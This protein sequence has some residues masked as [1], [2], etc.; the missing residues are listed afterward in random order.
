VGLVI[1][2]ACDIQ[3]AVY[4]GPITTIPILLFSGF[5]VT[6]ENIPFYMHWMSYVAYTR[7]GFEGT[8]LAIYGFDRETLKCSQPYCHFKYPQK[9]LEELSLDKG[10]F[11][12]DVVCLLA[13]FLLLRVSGYF[14]L[15][16]KVKSEK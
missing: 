2:C 6:L 1:G 7:Y 12:L 16:F 9:F 3:T 4:M 14:V 15:K 8:M 11:W 13:F 5:F 10:V